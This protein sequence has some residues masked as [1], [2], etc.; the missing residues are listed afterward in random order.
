MVQ[1]QNPGM[2]SKFYVFPFSQCDCVV[3]V[4]LIRGGWIEVLVGGFFRS[5]DWKL[6][7]IEMKLKVLIRII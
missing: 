7:L 4:V 5:G 2:K 6:V 1:E 3:D